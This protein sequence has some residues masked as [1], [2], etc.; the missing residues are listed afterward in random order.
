MREPGHAVFRDMRAGYRAHAAEELDQE[1]VGQQERRGQVERGEEDKHRTS[2]VIRAGETSPD[3]PH[4]PAIA[5]L[6][7]MVGTGEFR[8]ATTC[9][10]PAATPHNR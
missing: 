1:P 2:V 10:R 6:A 5:P 7:P 9:A 3:M 4:H 8:F